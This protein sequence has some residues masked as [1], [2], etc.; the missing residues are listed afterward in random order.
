MSVSHLVIVGPGQVGSTSR[1]IMSPIVRRMNEPPTNRVVIWLWLKILC[2]YAPRKRNSL[3]KLKG[4]KYI[5]GNLVVRR[6]ISP[7]IKD[8]YQGIICLQ[9]AF[10]GPHNKI[11]AALVT[12]KGK[13]NQ[14]TY[15]YSR[16]TSES[17]LVSSLKEQ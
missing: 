15:T 8:S 2:C 5:P 1:V 17:W 7:S 4:E 3:K 14:C 6:T 10:S 13:E 9:L 12:V 11:R 16:I